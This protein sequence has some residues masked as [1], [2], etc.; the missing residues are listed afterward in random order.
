MPLLRPGVSVAAV[1]GPG[2]RNIKQMI[3]GWLQEMGGAAVT[4][5]LIDSWWSKFYHGRG[6][7]LQPWDETVRTNCF[8][9]K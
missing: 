9:F 1:A 5:G 7:K 6:E 3:T 2:F 8:D 4:D